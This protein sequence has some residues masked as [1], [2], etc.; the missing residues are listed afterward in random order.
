MLIISKRALAF[1]LGTTGQPFVQIQ[2]KS[3]PQKI[4]DWCRDDLTFQTAVRA[5][6]AVEIQM[7]TPPAPVEPAETTN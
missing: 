1:G 7:P 5:G 4:P 6:L 3:R 2:P